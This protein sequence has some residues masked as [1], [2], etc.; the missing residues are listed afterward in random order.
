MPMCSCTCV[1]CVSVG[2]FFTVTVCVFECD[3]A[4]LCV[5]QQNDNGS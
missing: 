2:P 3:K 5:S 4:K 1:V